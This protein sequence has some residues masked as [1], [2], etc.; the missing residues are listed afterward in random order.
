[1]D[2]KMNFNSFLKLKDFV[3]VNDL[4]A[5]IIEYF[6]KNDLLTGKLSVRGKY[7]KQDMEREYHF[8]EDIPFNIVFNE[9][10]II[11]DIDC[12]SFDYQIVEGRG[13]DLSFEVEIKFEEEDTLDEEET[14]IEEIPVEIDQ[15]KEKAEVEN[16][17]VEIE[18][19]EYEI[20]NTI[21]E[22]L[23]EFKEDETKKADEQ[24]SHTL[25]NVSDNLPEDEEEV[26]FRNIPNEYKTIKIRY[27][28]DD[29]ELEKVCNENNMSIDQVFKVN[30]KNEFNKYRRI[31]INDQ[32]STK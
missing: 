30:R 7:L 21:E 11:E 2:I 4:S 3:K 15:E 16:N 26:I 5:E 32:E 18:T 1:M 28:K 27:Y 6:V 25:L 17:N 9:E 23:E 13:I 10:Y 20:R 29:E 24:L 31:I 12:I 19:T 8:D 22:E 14:E